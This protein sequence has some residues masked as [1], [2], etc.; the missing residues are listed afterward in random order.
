[1]AELR[2]VCDYCCNLVLVCSKNTDVLEQMH[3]LFS[4][5]SNIKGIVRSNVASHHL[6]AN[7][8]SAVNGCRQN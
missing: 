6:L 1:M 4:Y 7:G 2:T 8:S 3:L 5:I